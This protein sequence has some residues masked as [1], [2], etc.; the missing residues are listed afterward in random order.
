MCLKE[1]LAEQHHMR[2]AVHD[3]AGRPVIGQSPI[4]LEPKLPQELHRALQIADRKVNEQPS[5]HRRVP[6]SHFRVLPAN[7][8]PNPCLTGPS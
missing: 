1:W 7:S 6:G 3:Y 5:L 4:K 8:E 2:V